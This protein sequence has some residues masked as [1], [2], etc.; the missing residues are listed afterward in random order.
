MLEALL[1][2]GINQYATAGSPFLSILA[3]QQYTIIMSEVRL[4][5][6]YSPA[7]AFMVAGG[8]LLLQIHTPLFSVMLVYAHL[9]YMPI[10]L[11][12]FAQAES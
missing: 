4:L 1:S 3:P 11:Y 7:R 12:Y 5:E 9:W 8:F 10:V 6:T 2:T